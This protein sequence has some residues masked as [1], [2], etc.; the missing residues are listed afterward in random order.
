MKSAF[1]ILL[2]AVAVLAGCNRQAPDNEAPP[3]AVSNVT[4]M[5]APNSPAQLEERARSALATVLRDPRSAQLR[6]L[7]LGSGGAICGEVSLPNQAGGEPLLM[8]V[9]PTDEALISRTPTINLADPE[10]RFPDAYIQWCASPGELRALTAQMNNVAPAN[11]V[12]PPPIEELPPEEPA[13]AP[14]QSGRW[15]REAPP[16]T[17]PSNPSGNGFSDAVVRPP[18]P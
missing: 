9:T 10:D 3:S 13:P 5:L 1:G 7:R 2:T 12:E 8:L 15:N 11:L 16:G 6:N 18:R 14:T 4:N 17:A